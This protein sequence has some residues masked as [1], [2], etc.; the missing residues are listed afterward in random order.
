[1]R[2][3]LVEDDRID[4]KAIKRVLKDLALEVELHWA[5]DGGEAI[6]LLVGE[7]QLQRPLI[8]LLDLQLEEIDGQDVL[9]VLGD[10]RDYS[11]LAVF[12]FTASEHTDDRLDTEEHHPRGYLTKQSI[13]EGGELLRD[14]LVGAW[15]DLEASCRQH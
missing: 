13:G 5:K 7:E 4:W 15:Q 6:D 14:V 10:L 1:M 11:R 2:I 9:N 3:L 8:V 12:I